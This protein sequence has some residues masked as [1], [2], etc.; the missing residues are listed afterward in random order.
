MITALAALATVPSA[1]ATDANHRQDRPAVAI[2]RGSTWATYSFALPRIIGPTVELRLEHG[3]LRGLMASRAL[4]VTIRP[5][6][7]DGFGPNGPVNLSITGREA[8]LEV[9]GMWNG[10]PVHL[11]LE[12]DVLRGSVIVRPR[13]AG[14]ALEVSCGYRLD[15]VDAGGALVGSSACGGLPQ[16][17]RVEI[18]PRLRQQLAA[19]EL[20]VFLIAALAAPPISTGERI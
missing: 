8:G 12:P 15:R 3:I 14:E 18:D 13:G 17:T 2:R 20:A 5:G 1:C 7:A 19:H 4:N 9:H 10:G 11:V 6:G 16:D